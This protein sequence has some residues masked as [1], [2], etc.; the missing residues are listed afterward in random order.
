MINS[1][2]ELVS[3]MDRLMARMD[4]LEAR[5]S[6]L[7]RQGQEAFSASVT[8]GNGT[9]LKARIPLQ[10]TA[11]GVE[12]HP[13]EKVFSQPGAGI[14]PAIGKVFLGVAGAYIL[15]ALAES[16]A[17][18]Q[19]VI[20]GAGLAYAATW[21][22]WSARVSVNARLAGAAYAAT[23]ALILSP[24]LWELTVRFKV[25]PHG[26]TA[27]LLAAFALGGAAL[28]WKRNLTAITWMT[29][30]AAVF[31]TLALLISTRDPA[32][33]A[34]ALIF[35]AASIEVAACQGR[36]LSARTIVAAALDVGIL[37]LLIVYTAAQGIPAEY[38]LI[39]AGMLLFIFVAPILIYAVSTSWR[40]VVQRRGITVFEIAQSTIAFLLAWF[41]VSRSTH[42][43]WSPVLGTLA[44]LLA[45][46]CYMA[47]FARFQD[48]EHVRDY[49]VFATWGAALAIAGGWELLP[50]NA[51]VA[52][53]SLAA[54][55]VSFFGSRSR[56]LTVAFHGAAFLMAAW[57][58]SGF[59]MYAGRELLDSS[60][61]SPCIMGVIVAAVSFL[62]YAAVWGFPGN[63][64]QCRVVR[65]LYATGALL[66][67]LAAEVFVAASAWNGGAS[68]AALAVVRTVAIC[69]AALLLVVVGSRRERVEL[70][71]LA[72]ACLAVCTLKI[73]FEDLHS[74][75]PGGMAIALFAYGS[76]WVLLPR[77]VRGGSKS[78]G[79]S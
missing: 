69:A 40:S 26:L 66:A 8:R 7:E 36:S 38:R 56:R 73:L 75:S 33:F 59:L 50:G 25:L 42:S 64:W 60:P 54:V 15:R 45:A 31:T 22:V 10:S 28:G 68:G 14:A 72:Y 78:T 79:S 74:G 51:F 12:G 53:M 44:L 9:E 49:H 58:A 37:A 29:S 2:D 55:C 35:I 24:M 11:L 39:S 57:L 19:M 23:A 48:P 52:A 41:G 71:W 6:A 76:V 13:L 17:L 30:L 3:V 4:E 62:C 18:P 63:Q 77:W 32:P 21:M 47:A 1:L 46:G 27:V 43:P 16:G 34:F 20:V 61:S 67:L 5:I 65:L 70:V